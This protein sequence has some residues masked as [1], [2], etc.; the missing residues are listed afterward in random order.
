M[1][2]AILFKNQSDLLHEF[3]YF[4]P[5]AQAAKEQRRGQPTGQRGGS[6]PP[7]GRQPAQAV[8]PIDARTQPHKRKAA[9]KAEEGFKAGCEWG[10]MGVGCVILRGHRGRR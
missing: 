6:K 8:S 9:K 7:T 3:Q 10:E 1:K 4:L 5:D 2:V